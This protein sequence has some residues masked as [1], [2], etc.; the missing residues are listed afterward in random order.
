VDIFIGKQH[1]KSQYGIID[2][3]IILVNNGKGEFPKSDI[4]AM[5]LGMVNDARWA[6]INS[7]GQDDLVVASEWRELQ[8]LFNNGG[9]FNHT[10]IPN[11]S[12]LW[13]SLEVDDLD[14]DDIL[15]IVAGNIGTNTPLHASKEEPLTMYVS[16]FMQSG[17]TQPI[18]CQYED[19]KLYTYENRDNLSSEIPWIK[20]KYPNY[21]SFATATA[22][23]IFE[24]ALDNIPTYQVDHLE[25]KIFKGLGEGGFTQIDLPIAA[26]YSTI[27]SILIRDVND[28]GIKDIITGGN[29]YEM[30]PSLGR[31]DGSYMSCFVSNADGD[32]VD[33]RSILLN[34]EGQV[35]ALIPI[36]EKSILVGLNDDAL[37][38]I[39]IH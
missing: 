9:S 21:K 24:L 1:V 34:L 25:S 11:S 23:D 32:Y 30:S 7:D 15:D 8:I 37:R 39:S 3:S 18:I 28:D 5:D 38:L 14:G 33:D 4:L 19:G 36:N 10:I 29:L 22:R 31:L 12:G 6:D 2:K 27:E 13:R 17:F 20:K 35:R 16:D 26:Q